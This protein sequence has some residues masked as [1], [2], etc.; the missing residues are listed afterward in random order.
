MKRFVS[1]TVVKG[2]T[3]PIMKYIQ[4]ALVVA[5]F[6]AVASVV[7]TLRGFPRL[8]QAG[9]AAAFTTT[10]LLTVASLSLIYLFVAQDFSIKYVHHYSD[11]SMPVFYVITAFW[12]GQD[13]SLLFWAWIL[14]MY[15]AVA[16]WINREHAQLIPYATATLMSICASFM[17]LLLFSA[18]MAP[19]LLCADRRDNVIHLY[20]VRPLTPTDYVV[21]RYL[22]FFAI[23][24][25]I[26][27]SG[28]LVLQIGLV[29]SADN[30]LTYL[31]DS[32]STILRILA[33]GVVIAAFIAVIPL[34]VAAFTTRRAYA[35]AFVIGLFLT[36]TAVAAAL[37]APDFVCEEIEVDGRIVH[38]ECRPSDEGALTGDAA[39]W[40]TL[41]ALGEIPLRVNDLIFDRENDSE[42]ARAAADLPDALLVGW[43]LLFTA[44]PGALLWWRYQRIRI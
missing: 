20:L 29:L 8:Q 27:Y 18:I 16:L 30:P 42:I 35:A 14:S 28:Q 7:G 10:G 26:V 3:L 4:A 25:A 37:T 5:V 13:G 6:S 32:W 24:L 12:G 41:I 31:R 15:S 9:Y 38:T 39:K 1:T 40:F 19:E 23:V 22:A 33:A 17:I 34:A 44:G 2:S 21:G 43:Y 36:S 11:R